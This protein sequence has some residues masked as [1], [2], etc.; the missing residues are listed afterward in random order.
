MKVRTPK[1]NSRHGPGSDGGSCLDVERFNG[2][3]PDTFFRIRLRE[4]FRETVEPLQAALDEWLAHE[5]AGRLHPGYRNMG[6]NP[7]KP[8]C[9]SQDKKTKRILPSIP[10]KMVVV[11][12]VWAALCR[13]PVWRFSHGWQ[14]SSRMIMT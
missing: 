3:V 8:S 13:K 6:R 1:A 5:N 14:L 10:G 4:N 12:C 9:H 7:S 11:S 2:A